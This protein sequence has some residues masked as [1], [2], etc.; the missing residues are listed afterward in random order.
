MTARQLWVG[1]QLG[2]LG[3][4]IGGGKDEKACVALGEILGANDL[5]N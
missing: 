2:G 3:F 4:S 1:L 5:K